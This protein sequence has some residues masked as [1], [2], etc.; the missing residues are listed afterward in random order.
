VHCARWVAFFC[1]KPNTIGMNLKIP[2]APYK[3]VMSDLTNMKISL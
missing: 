3:T 1:F 2:H